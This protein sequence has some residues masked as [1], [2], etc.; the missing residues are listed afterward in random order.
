MKKIV[1]GFC[2]L[3]ITINASFSQPFTHADTLRGSNGQGRSWW[4]A[5]KYDLHVKFNLKDS[6]ISGYN[7]ISFKELKKDHVDYFQIDLQEPMIID[8]VILENKKWRDKRWK[9]NFIQD[10]NAWFIN[11]ND[12]VKRGNVN[13]KEQL[14]HKY[15]IPESSNL[16]IYYH[17]KPKIAVKPPWDGGITWT[18]DKQG[19]PWITITCQG[20][21]ASVWYPCKD[22]QCDEP[23]SASMHITAPSVLI[24]ISN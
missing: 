2:F 20:L 8:S 6:T 14:P 19:N 24:A 3:L 9:I 18:R 10:G 1:I 13:N 22:Y 15:F 7:I 17:G 21:G 4:N 23:D 11:L 16:F 12:S 5:T